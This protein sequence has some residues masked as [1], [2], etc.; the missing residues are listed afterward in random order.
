MA[1]TPPEQLL[2]IFYLVGQFVHQYLLFDVFFSTWFVANITPSQKKT[3]VSCVFFQKKSKKGPVADG[4][5][6]GEDLFADLIFSSIFYLI[7]K[8]ENI[9]NTSVSVPWY[10]RR[11]VG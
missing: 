1:D 11:S 3:E 5:P 2:N 9:A 4:P 10:V 6:P 7:W 8:C